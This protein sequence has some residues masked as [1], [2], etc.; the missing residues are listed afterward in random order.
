M[1]GKCTK[2]PAPF[3]ENTG[4]TVA[5]AEPTSDEIHYFSFQMTLKQSEIS[6]AEGKR[7][8]AKWQRKDKEV[9]PYI[10]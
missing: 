6:E 5:T 8:T 4:T 3:L 10:F 1:M 2:T 9:S 7:R